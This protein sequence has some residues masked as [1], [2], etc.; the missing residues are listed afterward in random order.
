MV[1]GQRATI[2]TR[3]ID[4]NASTDGLGLI[5]VGLEV[6]A[7]VWRWGSEVGAGGRAGAELWL[8]AGA[9]VGV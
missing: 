1:R 6:E 8:D 7:G 9:G 4:I 2:A 5:P 3:F